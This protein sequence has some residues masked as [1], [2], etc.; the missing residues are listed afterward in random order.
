M[1]KRGSNWAGSIPSSTWR[2]ARRREAASILMRS[3]TITASSK[4]HCCAYA[5]SA[6]M[7]SAFWRILFKLRNTRDSQSVSAPYR[8]DRDAGQIIDSDRGYLSHVEPLQRRN[9][10]VPIQLSELMRRATVCDHNQGKAAQQRPNTRYGSQR[11]SKKYYL[12]TSRVSRSF[13]CPV[14]ILDISAQLGR[15][16]LPGRLLLP[17]LNRPVTKNSQVNDH[18]RVF[19]LRKVNAP[20]QSKHMQPIYQDGSHGPGSPSLPSAITWLRQPRPAPGGPRHHGNQLA[21]HQ[22]GEEVSRTSRR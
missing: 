21:D 17:E 18:P 22:A 7:I 8:S 13:L 2:T 20:H 14:Q 3:V 19:Q 1:V 15:N 9:Q 6:S 5:A 10:I 12:W 11:S 4:F 16:R